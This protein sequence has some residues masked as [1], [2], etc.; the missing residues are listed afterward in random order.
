MAAR[1]SKELTDEWRAKIKS[2]MLVNRLMENALGELEKEMTTGQIKSAEIL[3]KKTFPDLTSAEDIISL[4]GKLDTNVN[5]NF[6]SA[7]KPS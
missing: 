6:V 3:L 2:S 4:N 5:V 1:I 7:D